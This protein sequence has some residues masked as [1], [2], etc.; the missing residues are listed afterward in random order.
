MVAAAREIVT[1]DGVA[2]CTVDEVVRRSG[3]AK[4]TLYRHFGGIDGLLLEVMDRMVQA[5]PIPD[6]GSLRGDLRAITERYLAVARVPTSRQLFTW[7]LSR[8]MEDPAFAER[9]RHVRV[10]PRGP[11]VIA[12]QRAIARGE[13]DPEIDVDLAM[14]V[15]Q[16]P[17]ISK[18]IIENEEPT[19][20]ELDAML[21]MILRALTGSPG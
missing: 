3:V 10:Q 14:H 8:S 12:L 15:V 4:T 2:W 6:T 9:F 1:L 7:M 21:A 5:S 20:A 18:R 11:T 13:L 16:G 19:P 17:M